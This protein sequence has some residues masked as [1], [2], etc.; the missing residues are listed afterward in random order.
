[1][2]DHLFQHAR[3][4]LFR[5]HQVD[6][7]TRIEITTACPHDHPSGRSQA[8]TGVDRSTLSDSC[9]AG[10]VAQMRNHQTRW[11]IIAQLTHDRFARKSVKP[12]TS[13]TRRAQF[14][15]NREGAGDFGYMSMKRGVEARDLR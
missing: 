9:N 3:V 4:E 7:Y 14:L 12:I 6:Q 1:M 10:S 15:G 11:Q 5:T 13:D 8:H 2:I